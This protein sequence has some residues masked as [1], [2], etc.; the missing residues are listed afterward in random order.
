M[1]S[2]RLA[3]TLFVLAG[4]VGYATVYHLWH[5]RGLRTERLHFW[6]AVWCA[7]TV[8]YLAGR[9]L[10]V[11][12]SEPASIVL[13]ARLAWISSAFLIVAGVGLG[14]ALAERADRRLVLVTAAGAVLLA[15]LIAATDLVVT[16]EVYLRTDRLGHVAAT[17]RP[18]PLPP[19]VVLAIAL[20]YGYFVV[21]V[22]RAPTLRRPERLALLAGST[23]YVLTGINDTLHVARL[24]DSVQ[25][26]QFGFVAVSLGL[27]Y[28]LAHR[29]RLLRAHLEEQVRE[30]TSQLDGLVRAGRTVMAGLALDATLKRIVDEA[31]RIAG[32]PHLSVLLLEP[33][34][35]VLRLAAAGGAYTEPFEVPADGSHSGTVATTRAPLFLAAAEIA[36]YRLPDVDRERGLVTYLGL[37]IQSGGEVLGVLAIGTEQPR[38]WSAEEIAVLSSFADQAAVALVNARLYEAEAAA[39]AQAED[40]LAQVQTLRG[41]LP[42]CAWCKRIRNDQ[43]YWEQIDSYIT[44]HSAATFTHGICP[45]CRAKMLGA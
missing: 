28:L 8:L 29:Y 14:A 32:T 41:L 43:N 6:A 33:E 40:A 12:A 11:T 1:S 20:A 38:I 10:I 3:A 17:V 27:T 9:L 4:A 24:I 18:G 45:D 34:R 22:G 23:F 21:R 2:A 25:V 30:R 31:A 36:S 39:R 7:D 13:G 35:R 19:L 37:P 42:I 5:W 16:R 15:L 26:F 44:A